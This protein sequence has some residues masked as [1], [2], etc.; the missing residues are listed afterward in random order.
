MVAIMDRRGLNRMDQ[1]TKQVHDRLMDWAQAKRATFMWH[2]S[3]TNT[4]RA[5][6]KLAPTDRKVIEAYYLNWAPRYLMCKREGLT[7]AQF[8]NTLMRARFRVAAFITALD[9]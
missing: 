8:R 1:A 6:S 2:P 9:D 3:Q 5:V 7:D 4:D